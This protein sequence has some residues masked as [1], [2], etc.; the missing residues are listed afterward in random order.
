MAQTLFSSALRYFP[1]MISGLLL[2][3]GFSRRRPIRHCLFRPGAIVDLPGNTFPPGKGFKAGLV[4]GLTHF[5][6]L[7]YWLV[8]TL[9]QYGGLNLCL[10][11]ATLVLLC[12]YLALYPGLLPG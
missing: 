11:L 3:L 4:T 2:T 5:L 1:A 10:S 6:S 12:L 8:P 9:T 7:I